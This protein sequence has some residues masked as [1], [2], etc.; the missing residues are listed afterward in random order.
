MYQNF[1]EEYSKHRKKKIYLH[2]RKIGKTEVHYGQN[3]CPTFLNC[4]Y[5][6]VSLSLLFLNFFFSH[7]LW[8]RVA[9]E[10]DAGRILRVRPYFHS[11]LLTLAIY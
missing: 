5:L 1:G 8:N 6:A 7:C 3:I 9:K 11:K 10:K 4:T 2:F